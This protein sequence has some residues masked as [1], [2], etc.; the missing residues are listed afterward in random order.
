MQQKAEHDRNKT[1][2][3]TAETIEFSTNEDWNKVEPK[4]IRQLADELKTSHTQIR[5]VMTDMGIEGTSQGAGKA[6]LIGWEDQQA[7]ARRIKPDALATVPT[8][9]TEVLPQNGYGKRFDMGNPYAIHFHIHTSNKADYRQSEQVADSNIQALL[10]QAM[11]AK[12][13]QGQED[14]QEVEAVIAAA[15]SKLIEAGIAGLVAKPGKP[16]DGSPSQSPSQS[17]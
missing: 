12:F 16:V 4:S 8:H 3:K 1:G 2:T 17:E 15:K 13:E 7:I 11:A 9:T 14:Q 5:R 10:N 6:T